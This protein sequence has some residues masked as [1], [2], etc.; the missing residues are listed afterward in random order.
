MELGPQL[1]EETRFLRVFDES[2][3]NQILNLQAA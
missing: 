2:A 3:M 1:V